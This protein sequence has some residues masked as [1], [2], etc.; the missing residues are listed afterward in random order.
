MDPLIQKQLSREDITPFHAE[1]LK[2]CKQLV[3]WSRRTM[4]R[5]Y[6][7]WDHY[8][9][10][11]RGMRPPDKQDQKA[12]ERGEPVKMVVPLS[13]AQVQTFVAFCF[14]MY[15]QREHIFEL[16]GKGREDNLPAKI[17]EALLARDLDYNNFDSRLYQFLLDVGRFGLGI[18]KS[19]WMHE[20]QKMPQ[21]VQT[22]GLSILGLQL[23]APREAV[24][25]AD[26]TKF[27]GNKVTNVSPYRFYP[28]V[29]LPISRFQEG[30]FAASEDEYAVTSLYQME[31]EGVVAGVKYIKPITNKVLEDRG[32]SRLSFTDVSDEKGT[33]VSMAAAKSPGVTL[34][35]ECQVA[36]IPSKFM[37]ESKPLGKETYPVKYNVWY[38]NDQRVIKCEPLGYIHNQFTYD[39][40]EFS[41]DM[42]NLVN[43]GLCETIDQLQS[44]ITWLINSHVTSVRKTIDNKLVVDP[45]GVRME[46]I[47]NRS[48]VIRLKDGMAR[49]G[50]ERWVHQLDVRDVTGNHMSDAVAFQQLVQ[51]VTGINDNA[52]GQFH[53]GRR[54]ATEARNVNSATASRLKMLAQLIFKSGLK[55]LGQK[56]I[57]NLRDGLDEDT[58]VRVIGDTAD[59]QTFQEFKK[60]SKTDLVGDYDFEIFDGT[61]PSERGVQAQG[62]QE[63]LVALLS[64]PMT[65]LILGFDPQVI[66]REVLEL[67]NVRH[68]ERFLAT[69]E[70][71]Q[72]LVA[73][74]TLME[75]TPN[76]SNKPTNGSSA[77]VRGNGKGRPAPGTG[78]LDAASLLSLLRGGTPV[79]G[80]P[81]NV[82]PS[83]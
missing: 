82:A 31:H 22:P 6:S 80:V 40:A 48:P 42:H 74:I 34:V 18:I 12:K 26:V 51:I 76:A 64:N 32:T 25:L 81:T 14:A 28:D 29:R 53:Q 2:H 45:A 55:T 7:D 41:P 44:V 77:S 37:I 16:I 33:S 1:M 36:L 23:R 4:A 70:V 17:A 11:Y 15:Y 8:N 78:G 67:R 56:M 59:Q 47:T 3:N 58:Y 79:P 38:A 5:H 43:A 35:T 73:K 83:R 63:L 75:N 52:L 19:G 9:D 46:D 27:L 13:Y 54:S 21:T 65:I 61:L 49:T 66:A 20:T 10:V 24:E 69:P 72:Q 39:V 68:P 30:E 50:V 60:V 57:S 62:L 71:L